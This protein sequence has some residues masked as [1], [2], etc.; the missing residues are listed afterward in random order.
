MLLIQLGKHQDVVDQRQQ[1]GGFPANHVGK[2]GNV[3]RLGNAIAN[4]FRKTGD[5]GQRR[6]QLVGDVGREF[7]ATFFG[8]EAL[9]HVQQQK[10][11]ATNGFRFHD[12][13]DVKFILLFAM[14]HRQITGFPRQR[15]LHHAVQRHIPGDGKQGLS[16]GC[17]R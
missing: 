15:T 17:L 7:P 1:P 16:D 11:H 13:A 4:N 12:R 6:F 2:V 8:G 10:H 3:L 5:G 14:I 9:C